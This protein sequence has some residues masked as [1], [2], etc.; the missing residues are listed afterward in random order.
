MA[1]QDEAERRTC[2]DLAQVEKDAVAAIEHAL[3][4]AGDRL[5]IVATHHPMASYGSHRLGDTSP[6]DIP[7]PPYQALIASLNKA[8]AAHPPHL[9]IAGHDHDLQILR[10]GPAG[11]PA[12]LAIVSGAG[13]K[14]R[15][16]T[17][18]PPQDQLVF[19]QGGH[20]GFMTLDLLTDGRI[21][22]TVTRGQKA[23]ARAPEGFEEQIFDLSTLLKK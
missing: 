17:A 11:V 8:L 2:G 18:R 16:L 23:G 15:D 21:F 12:R 4:T 20:L 13:S 7:S 1:A 3:A 9:F 10:G 6:Q 22:L 19:A 14:V 5:T